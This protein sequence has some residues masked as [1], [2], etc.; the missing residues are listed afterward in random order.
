M[1]NY[2]CKPYSPLL[3]NLDHLSSYRWLILIVFFILGSYPASAQD[4]K[5]SLE[6]AIQWLEEADSLY[7]AVA[8]DSAETKYKAAREIFVAHED[9]GHSVEILNKLSDM[10]FDQAKDSLGFTCFDLA[11]EEAKKHLP[12]LHPQRGVTSLRQFSILRKHAETEE[13]IQVAKTILDSAYLILEETDLYRSRIKCHL[14]MGIWRSHLGQFEAIPDLLKKAYRLQLLH[15]PHDYRLESTILQNIIGAGMYQGDYEL[16]FKAGNRVMELFR[17]IPEENLVFNDTIVMVHSLGLWGAL[18]RMKNENYK[19]KKMNREA[20]NLIYSSKKYPNWL[21]YLNHGLLGNFELTDGNFELALD[22][23]LIVE[24]DLFENREIQK[25]ITLYD[26]FVEIG[27]CLIELN[28]EEKALEYLEKVKD[29]RREL[30]SNSTSGI[31]LARLFEA[32]GEPE[33]A[34]QYYRETFS[35]IRLCLINIL[36]RSGG[37]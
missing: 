2:S 32:L 1:K 9:W 15:L 22:H 19:A 35:Q 37:S 24:K 27:I 34:L 28:R 11:T 7:Y 18:F 20:L 17:K 31:G 30:P 25:K 33:L 23:L 16:P 6:Q 36:P 3:I 12:V 29:L 26:A 4:S 10:Y 8:Y 21:G 5:G 13:E 14:E